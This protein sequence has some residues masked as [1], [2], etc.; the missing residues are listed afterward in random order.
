VGIICHVANYLFIINYFDVKFSPCNSSTYTNRRRDSS[1]S[2]VTILRAARARFRIPAGTRDYSFPNRSD[3]PCCP[4]APYSVGT[5][6][7]SQG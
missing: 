7:I 3:L 2:T 5:V 4:Q 1:D 6:V